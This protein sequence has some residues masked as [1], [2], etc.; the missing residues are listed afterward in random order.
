MRRAKTGWDMDD[1]TLCV[2]HPKVSLEGFASLAVP[3]YRASTIPFP[4]SA[5]YAGRLDRGDDSYVYGL[6]GTPTTRT[7]EKQL[8]A[9]ERAERCFLT[10]SGQ[11]AIFIAMAALLEPGDTVL[12]TDSVYAPVRDLATS[13]LARFGVKPVFFD[14]SDPE[15]PEKLLDDSVRMIWVESP[16]STTMEILDLPAIVRMAKARGILVG[17]DNT[18]ATPYLLKPLELGA[19]I[20]VQALSKYV[21]GHSDVLMGSIAVKDPQLAARI[22]GMMWRTG[23]GVSPDDCSLVLR[24]LETLTVRLAHSGTV[25]ERLARWIAARPTVARV[26]H[27][28]LETAPGHAIWKRDF[29]GA[30]GVFTV[31]LH[32][33]AVPH[34][35]AALDEL[36]LISIGASWGGT[37][38]LVAPMSVAKYR[39]ASR[40]DGADMHLR[41]SIGLEAEE[42]LERDLERFFDR[43]EAL[44]SMPERRL[45]RSSV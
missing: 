18:W 40:V 38:S 6:Y 30:S 1:R 45:A 13:D 17:C 41:F 28:A 43:I 4:D 16:G 35:P 22:K 25:G 9:L 20:S 7:L 2:V 24:G 21:G 29:K 23:T 34:V 8:A 37:R 26:L 15:G 32:D 5:A 44:L 19:D 12:I 11:S 10:P 33:D 3:T 31:V 36:T 14:P 39:T 42:D 27:P